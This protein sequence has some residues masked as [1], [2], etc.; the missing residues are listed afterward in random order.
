MNR[1]AAIV[2]RLATAD[3]D[4]KQRLL[5]D[6]LEAT[7]E[8]SRSIAADILAG[9]F[10]S[11]RVKL[12]LIRGLAETR[13]DPAL[14][15][16]SLDYVGDV[17]ETIAL[18]WPQQRRANRAPAL[19]EIVEALSTLGRSEL[20]K[21]IEAW[22]DACDASGRWALIKLITG[23]LAPSTK[24]KMGETAQDEIFAPPAI[25]SPAGTIDAILLYAERGRSK[26]QPMTCTFGL[27]RDGALVPVG[28]AAIGAL[29]DRDRLD[30]FIRDNTTNRFGPV[31]EV[32][33][34][35]VLEIAF[36]ELQRSRRRKSGIVLRNARIAG[37][38]WDTPPG[39]AAALESLVRLLPAR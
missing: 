31:R 33:H 5:A 35:L 20:P 11:R 23:T 14:Y 12:A 19:D 7:P 3:G 29:D 22:L 27:W 13:L 8:P 6:Y 36:D 16:L 25:S 38:R 24:P 2:D 28:K 34:A 17:A 15:A 10:K 1:F 4:M 30:A 18:L 37:I 32:A 9:S 39:G 26:S 21:R